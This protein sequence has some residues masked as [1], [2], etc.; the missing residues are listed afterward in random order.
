MNRAHDGPIGVTTS[1]SEFLPLQKPKYAELELSSNLSA[2]FLGTGVVNDN[3][4]CPFRSVRTDLC[5][6]LPVNL[7]EDRGVL[8][9]PEFLSCIMHP[10]SN[11]KCLREFI[12]SGCNLQL[13]QFSERGSH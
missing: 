5:R 10:G 4:Q 12:K 9:F 7:D 11:F 3:R 13:E 1:P 8:K 6:T 2:R